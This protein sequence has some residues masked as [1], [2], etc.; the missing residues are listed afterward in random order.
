MEISPTQHIHQ[1]E[2]KQYQS[3]RSQFW[4]SVNVKG[5]SYFGRYYQNT[6]GYL[7]QSIVPKGLKV[8]E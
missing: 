7:F 8:L 6:L 3:I 4:D 1:E 2:F 5:V